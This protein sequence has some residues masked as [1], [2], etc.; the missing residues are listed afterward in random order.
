MDAQDE[1]LQLEFEDRE[2]FLVKVP[3]R[4]MNQGMH[5]V[6]VCL[7]VTESIGNFRSS[8]EKGAGK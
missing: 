7:Y 3:V 5:A 4:V 1:P 6:C 2:L 8:M